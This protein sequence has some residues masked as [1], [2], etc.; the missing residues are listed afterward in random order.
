MLECR[1]YTYSEFTELFHTR[2]NAG[3]ARRLNRWGIRF[4]KKGR[5]ANATYNILEIPDPFKVYCILELEVSPQ[6][7]FDKFALFLYYLLN[8]EAF[9]GLPCERMEA[10]IRGDGCTLTRQ[11][12]E[13][14]LRRLDQ[15]NLISRTSYNYHYY[16]AK[17][18]SLID[19]TQEQYSEAW[20]NYWKDIESG[21]SSRDAIYRMCMKYGGVAR[22]QHIIDFNAFYNKTMDTLNDMVCERIEG[23]L[24]KADQSA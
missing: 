18:G 24:D 20:R 5:G 6:T 14:Y 3:M 4:E 9:A 10:K 22:K 19:T 2:D 12:I 17:S 7:D 1:T 21:Y 23:K 15:K 8:D 13:T 11:T 16:F